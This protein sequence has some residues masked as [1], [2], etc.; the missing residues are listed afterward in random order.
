VAWASRSG[1]A[2]ALDAV[3]AD[4]SLTKGPSRGAGIVSR[5]LP[6]GRNRPLI[7][8]LSMAAAAIVLVM[9]WGVARLGIL[10]LPILF[11]G[12]PLLRVIRHRL[13][14]CVVVSTP[15]TR[16]PM[17]C[18]RC[19]YSMRGLAGAACPECGR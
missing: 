12:V 4:A 8:S 3:I 10:S 18:P 17:L 14:W 9:A 15:P 13:W 1:L 2:R 11:A 7:W 6:R 19:G 5:M 16:Y